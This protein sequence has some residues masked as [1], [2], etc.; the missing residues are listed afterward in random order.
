M[1]IVNWLYYNL[2]YRWRGGNERYVEKLER[3]NRE[4]L[5][6]GRKRRTSKD[7]VQN[8]KSQ[9]EFDLIHGDDTAGKMMLQ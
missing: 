7:N 3:E 5:G 4:M 1:R 9:Y 2:F 8:V 6:M